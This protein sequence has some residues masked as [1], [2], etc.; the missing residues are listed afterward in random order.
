MGSF[1]TLNQ[2]TLPM[3]LCNKSSQSMHGEFL[4]IL[5]SASGLLVSDSKLATL[6]PNVLGLSLFISQLVKQ[7]SGG[8][9]TNRPTLSTLNTLRLSI[10]S[11]QGGCPPPSIPPFPDTSIS[12]IC[13]FRSQRNSGSNPIR[14]FQI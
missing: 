1:S 7:R 3:T 5:C 2:H 4:A 13:L 14:R 12:I 8:K 6:N 9:V 11:I 10:P